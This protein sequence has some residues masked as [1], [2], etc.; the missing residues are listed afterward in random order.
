MLERRDMIS[1][2]LCTEVRDRRKFSGHLVVQRGGREL[3]LQYY[4]FNGEVG[5]L[6][7]VD[8]NR[9][10]AFACFRQCVIRPDQVGQH[11]RRNPLRSRMHSPANAGSFGP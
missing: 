10:A 9:A 8:T 1:R 7:E 3:V 5:L 11:W 4:S 6:L 2:L